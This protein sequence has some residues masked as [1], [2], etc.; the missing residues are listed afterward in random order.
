MQDLEGTVVYAAADLL[1]YL[2]C[3]HLTSLERAAIG[4]L[5]LRPTR[6]DPERE[7]L[8]QSGLE[9]ERRY[10]AFLQEEGRIVVDGR[11]STE[12][13][14]VPCERGPVSAA[15]RNIVLLGDPQ[16]L[17]QVRKGARPGGVDLSAPEWVRAGEPVSD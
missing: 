11:H 17:S 10:L 13:T 12:A 1:G 14:P 5:V 3:E 4:K 8:Q 9:H 2:E 7:V 6:E 15:A 16:Q